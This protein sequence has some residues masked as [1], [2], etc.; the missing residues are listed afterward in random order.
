MLTILFGKLAG[1]PSHG[2]PYALLVSAGT[3]AW[4]LFSN[5]LAQASGSLASNASLISRVYFPRM[6]IPGAVVVTCLVD[7]AISLAIIVALMAWYG[8][9]PD[10]R[11]A[12]L[13]LFIALVVV[14]ALGFGLLFTA[15]NAKYRDFRFVVPFL[16]ALG[17]Y[18]S[19]VGFTS[20]IVPDTWRTLFSLNPMVGAIDGFR[21]ALMAEASPLFIP[22]L[23]VS[24][25]VSVVALLSGVAYFRRTEKAFAD[26]I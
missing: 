8:S 7:F 21:W 26:V 13:P 9:W 1:L 17:L 10:W 15:L 11:I 6:I 3:L 12:L 25:V 4:Q 2:A 23:L 19:P 24:A 22:G 14:A 18:V 16:L 5:T 20:D